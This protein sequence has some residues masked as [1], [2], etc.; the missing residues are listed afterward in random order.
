MADKGWYAGFRVGDGAG[1]A[2]TIKLRHVTKCH[3]YS[4]S[5]HD[6]HNGLMSYSIGRLRDYVNRLVTR[7]FGPKSDVVTGR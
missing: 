2:H 1:K 3:K 5:W 4:L 6:L 7:I